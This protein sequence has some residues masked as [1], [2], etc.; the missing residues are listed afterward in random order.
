MNFQ[1]WIAHDF[2]GCAVFFGLSSP[3]AC[4]FASAAQFFLFRSHFGARPRDSASSRIASLRMSAACVLRLAR[5]IPRLARVIARMHAVR[6]HRLA[7]AC[8]ALLAAPV[9]LPRVAAAWIRRVDA[10]IAWISTID[11]F[12][13]NLY[14]F[15]MIFTIP[16]KSTQKLKTK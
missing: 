10:W 9:L 4:V 8:C 2:P 14:D 13:F 5:V 11:Q 15:C 12:S 16:N 6:A 3:S 1:S 7:R